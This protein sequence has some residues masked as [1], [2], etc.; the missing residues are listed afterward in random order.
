MKLNKKLIFS[1][2]LFLIFLFFLLTVN[3]YAYVI[4]EIEGTT[5][6]IPDF[7]HLLKYD[8]QYIIY[9]STHPTVYEYL[10]IDSPSPLYRSD[11]ESGLNRFKNFDNSSFD[12]YNTTSDKK[13]FTFWFSTS[14]N[15]YVNIYNDSVS[16]YSNHDI[17][18]SLNGNEIFFH[19]TPVVG[20][21]QVIP[22]LEKVEEIP[23][24]MGQTLKILIPVGLIVL[25]IGFV[26]LLIK[27]VMYLSQ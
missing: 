14:V 8:Y 27:R 17:M 2:I 3:T 6:N 18:S 13:E 25:A 1:F 24:A 20:M 4:V 12:L 9:N 23:Q 16:L 11:Y 15:K 7:S 19:L 21:G 10:L 26:I 5:Y 22:A